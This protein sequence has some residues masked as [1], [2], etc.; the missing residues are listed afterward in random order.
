MKAYAMKRRVACKDTF[1]E[2]A[3]GASL[4]VPAGEADSEQQ[5]GKKVCRMTALRSL[6]ALLPG[7]EIGWYRGSILSSLL[8]REFFCKTPWYT[9]TVLLSHPDT[10]AWYRGT[11][12]LSRPG[13]RKRFSCHERMGKREIWKITLGI[14]NKSSP[15]QCKNLTIAT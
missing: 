10:R 6:S 3:D 8:G 14:N 11:V 7:G 15:L 9:G 1:R 5:A 13:T 4:Q 2:K 12:L